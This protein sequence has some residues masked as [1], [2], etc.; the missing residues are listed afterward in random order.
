MTTL[1]ALTD[2]RRPQTLVAITPDASRRGRITAAGFGAL[3]YFGLSTAFALIFSG[4]PLT[5]AQVV[6]LGVAV[7][8]GT[9]MV[10]ASDRRSWLTAAGSVLAAVA[11]VGIAAFALIAL[12]IWGPIAP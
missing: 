3:A 1:T 12:L 4:A 2:T 8:A 11:I 7:L 10:G 9:K 5:V 6:A